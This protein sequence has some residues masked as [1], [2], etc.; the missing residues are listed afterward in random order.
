VHSHLVDSA[1]FGTNWSTPESHAIFSEQSRV[2]RWLT[3]IQILGRAQAE[4]GIIPMSSA[5]AIEAISID[6]VD[7]AKVAD[8]TRETSHSTLG[9][10]RVL[11]GLLPSDAGG[12][13]YYGATVQDVSDTSASLEI[14]ALA[15]LMRRDLLSIEEQLLELAKRFRDTPML[16]RTHG[17]PG[18]P[19]SFGFKV[20][21]WADEVARNIE[22]LDQGAQRW[23]PAQLAGAVGVV[24]FYG[25]HASELRARFAAA[26]GLSNPAVTWTASRDRS[27]EFANVCGLVAQNLAR[28]A[29]EVYNLQRE[30]IGEVAERTSEA[31][32]GS[33]TMPHKRNPERSEQVVT[34]ARVIRALAAMMTEGMVGDHERDGRTWKGEWLALPQLGHHMLAS[35]SLTDALVGGLE[36]D[37][38]KMAQNL[39]NLGHSES[40]ELLRRLSLRMG[41]HSAQRELNRA[42]RAA[43]ATGSSVAEHLSD[44][45]NADDL[46]GLDE[47]ALGA[48]PEMVDAVVTAARRRDTHKDSS[49]T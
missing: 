6:D 17:Q 11:E 26:L 35:L 42:Y 44:V 16:G 4:L 21:G 10:I 45:L 5:R 2:E 15:S 27:A 36:V 30:E 32:V 8:L 41:K 46:E 18:A 9:L 7:L 48:G 12:H 49:R 24:A 47:P 39:A 1:I 25:Q 31:T 20:A 22:R 23:A 33:I 34:L 14:V 43:S 19:I 29:N 38:D 28:I 13:V 40:Q 37:T 3:I